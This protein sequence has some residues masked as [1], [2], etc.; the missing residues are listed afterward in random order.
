MQGLSPI[1]EE[2]LHYL[3]KTKKIPVNDTVTTEGDKF[4]II[5]FGVY[6]SDSGPDFF[7]GKVKI[8]ET[9]W[10]GNIEMHVF[11]SEWYVHRHQDDKA[12]ENVILH[13]VYE[14]DKDIFRSDGTIIN[15][16]ELKGKIPR[17]Y[18]ENYLRLYQSPDAL[19]CSY[20]LSDVDK[21]KIG[22][23]QHT[24]VAERLLR[25]SS[26]INKLLSQTHQ[27]WEETFYIVLS[28]YFGSRVNTDPFEQL[29]ASTPLSV[30]RKN[31]DNAKIIEAV[32]FGQAGMLDAKYNDEYFS[33]LK[34][35]YNYQRSKYNLRP[36]PAVMWKFSRMRPANFPTIRIAQLAAF[37]SGNEAVFQQIKHAEDIKSIRVLFKNQPD[38]Y[39]EKH[40][41]FD[42]PAPKKQS[43]VLTDSFID[44]LIINAVAP[45]VFQYGKATDDPIYTEKAF[46]ILEQMAPEKNNIIT[47]WN[48]LGIPAEKAFNSQALIQL[49]SEYCNRKRCLECSIGH[50]VL[51]KDRNV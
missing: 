15:T 1:K 25:K 10:A 20:A 4:E 44:L 12:Y 26:W 27:D 21:Q 14:H 42:Y 22:L 49:R 39:W 16:L 11:S 51:A 19:P 13:V 41:R 50:E 23:W 31:R 24:L 28:R 36:I 8:G 38:V 40:Y 18:L 48:E 29:A 46:S 45:V 34:K 32:L 35:E 17:I 47:S 43:A 33:E 6:N 30:L 5:D 9:L 3:W 37:I 2:F 7:N